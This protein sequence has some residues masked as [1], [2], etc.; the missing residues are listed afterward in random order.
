MQV[1]SVRVPRE[2]S[3][4]AL[5]AHLRGTLP[6]DLGVE[7]ARAVDRSFHAQWSATQ[8]EYRYRLDLSAKPEN[9]ISSASVWA[10]SQEPRLNGAPLDPRGLVEAL[11]LYEGEHDFGAFHESSSPRRLRQI[12]RAS[13][14]PR[15]EIWEVT[16]RG[17]AFGRHM[18]RYMVGAAVLAAG[19]VVSCEAI[20]DA[21][22]SGKPIPGLRAP[23][24]GLVLWE[25]AYPPEMDPFPEADRR[26]TSSIPA[27]LP[28]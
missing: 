24:S 23:P 27:G 3:P 6:A 14:K 1:I 16:L 13:A 8:K 15:G 21:V 10:P 22:S 5:E 25:V 18:A 9:P 17:S 7:R 20:R 12:F 26:S 28:F 4:A 11:A 19:G 2:I